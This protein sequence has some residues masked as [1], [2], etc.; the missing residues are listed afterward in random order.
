MSGYVCFYPFL[1]DPV[2][3]DHTDKPSSSYSEAIEILYTT[4]TFSFF[5]PE[6]L[7]LF[8]STLLPTRVPLIRHLAFHYYFRLR[9]IPHNWKRCCTLLRTLPCLQTLTITLSYYH[10]QWQLDLESEDILSPLV[11]VSVKG[12]FVVY[13][14]WLERVREREVAEGAHFRVVRPENMVVDKEV[15]REPIPDPRIFGYS[16]RE[17]WTLREDGPSDPDG[18]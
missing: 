14:D 16:S 18:V 6:T 13:I 5:Q 3:A 7:I 12:E 11:D 9:D 2:N 1:Q 4:N 10:V 17:S 8:P 15:T